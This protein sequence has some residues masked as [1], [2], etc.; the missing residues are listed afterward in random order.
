MVARGNSRVD[1][2]RLAERGIRPKG[3]DSVQRAVEMRDALKRT[4]DELT[5]RDTARPHRVD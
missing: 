2:S 4:L 3:D 1:R 5:G